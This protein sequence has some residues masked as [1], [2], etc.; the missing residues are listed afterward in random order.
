MTSPAPAWLLVAA[1]L[2]PAGALAQGRGA[3]ER[4]RVFLD[5]QTHGCDSRE[6][7]TEIG[8]VDW[9]LERTVSDVHVIATSQDTGAGTEYVLDF[10]GRGGFEG[11]DARLVHAAPSTDTQDEVLRALTGLLKAGLVSYVARSGY[12]DRLEI[13]ESEAPSKA[14]QSPAAPPNDPWRLW[15]FHVGGDFSA[16]GEERQSFRRLG[17]RLSANRTTPFWKIDIEVE[18]SLDR[19]EVELNDGR[20]FLNETDDWEADGLFV[21]S[22]SAHWS[23]GTA[24]EASTSTELNRSLGARSALALEWS[25]FPY[26]EANRKQLVV[27]YQ[28]GL[29]QVEYEERTIF[30]KIEERLGDQ[31]LAVAYD[32]R[33]PWGSASA[34]VQYSGLLD[35]WQKYRLSLGGELSFR[36]FRGL[37]LEIDGGYEILRDQLYLPAEDLSDEEILVQRRQLA[38]GYEYEIGIGFSYRFGS[39][40]N[41][42]VNNRF[43]GSVRGF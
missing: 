14:A 3:G 4:V 28:V 34:A 24:V 18:G 15:V 38:T 43:P 33:Q 7:R 1:L 11:E 23:A 6:F 26:Q 20:V 31:R 17:A 16:D 39:I 13:R 27:H 36:V 12:A 21:R 22:I 19:Q 30:G 32:A 41:N 42:V 40:Y 8:F 35:D 5:C 9:V 25:L 10:L 29:S 37:E 2:F